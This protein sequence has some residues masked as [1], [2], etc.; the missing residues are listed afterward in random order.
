[1]PGTVAHFDDE[2][3]QLQGL[4][5]DATDL[6]PGGGRILRLALAQT[7]LSEN[8]VNTYWPPVIED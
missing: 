6:R 3:Q 7:L 4:Q 1:M 2:T 8:T 5:A